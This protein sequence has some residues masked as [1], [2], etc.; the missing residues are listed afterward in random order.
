MN[1][2]ILYS[3]CLQKPESLKQLLRCKAILGIPR[4]IHNVRRDFKQPARVVAAGNGLRQL[5]NRL[6]QKI[7]VRD[8]VQVD[9]RA[10]LCRIFKL[11]C[12]RVI[13]GKHN[14]L[15]L[16]PYYIAQHKLRQGRAVTATAVLT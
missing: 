3:L 2:K 5:S 4:I 7:N 16:Y 1:P 13:G 12:R 6:F 10:Y 11:L 9:C 8:V 14:V 15:T